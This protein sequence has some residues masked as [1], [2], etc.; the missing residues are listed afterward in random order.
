MT[1]TDF[2]LARI[3]ED[4]ERAEFV[5]RQTEGTPW[6]PFEP[7]LLSWHDEYDLLCIEP[8]RALSEVESK[9]R[10]VE[11]LAFLDRQTELTPQEAFT[12]LHVGQML[13]LP[14]ADHP[15]YRDEWRP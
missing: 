14:Y 11:H 8:S 10:I 4:E 6:E 5:R 2:L 1:L 13:A 7:W 9:R 15:D 12:A 3:A